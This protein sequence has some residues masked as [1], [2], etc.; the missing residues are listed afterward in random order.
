MPR[1]HLKMQFCPVL[2]K[3]KVRSKANTWKSV[4]GN[5]QNKDR[6]EYRDKLEIKRREAWYT[7]SRLVK[8]EEACMYNISP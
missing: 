7:D 1:V 6:E 4:A 8:I 5:C 2:Y 3:L